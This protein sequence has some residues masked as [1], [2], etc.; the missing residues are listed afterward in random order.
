MLVI[1]FVSAISFLVTLF[2]VP[3]VAR[4]FRDAGLTGRD[5]HKRNKP[6]IP[7]MGGVAVVAGFVAGAL[8]AIAITT[9]LSSSFITEKNLTGFS[10]LAEILAAIVTI[11][12]MTIIGMFD[13]LV[14]IRQ[15]VKAL[16][17]IFASLP[18][19]AVAAGHPYITV[20]LLGQLYLPLLYPL[21]LIPIAVTVVSN[22]TNMLAGFNGLE[23]G[24][25]L[26]ACLSLGM[27]AYGKGSMDASILLFSMSA[28]LFAFL[29]FNRYPAKILPGDVGTLSIGACIVTAVIIGNFETAG[30]VVMIPY[31]ADFV[32]K[33][34][35]HF[36]KEI[37][38]TKL[39][40]GKLYAKKVV[41]LPSLVMDM[42]NGITETRLVLYLVSLQVIFGLLAIL[43]W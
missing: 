16:L 42:A 3:V 29:L 38:Y 27:I 39:R 33:V 31:I 9:L 2:L 26:I 4:K 18:L 43:I 8:L 30:L 6:E 14:R 21:I 12:A 20:P 24:M 13:D 36:P 15:S 10:N 25:G 19:V 7:E 41:G 23:S 17:P 11:L 5:V 40:N 35:N 34:K 22:L 28:A 32:I 1:L 37:E